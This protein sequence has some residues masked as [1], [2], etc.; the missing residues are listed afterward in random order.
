MS[1]RVALIAIAG[2]AITTGASA[3]PD[4]DQRDAKSPKPAAAPLVVA[5][6]NDVRR[7]ATSVADGFSQPVRHP[8]PRVTTCRCG[9]PQPEQDQQPDD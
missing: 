4:K 2:A 7:P 8:A 6:A 3:Q 1:I 5:L 9:D